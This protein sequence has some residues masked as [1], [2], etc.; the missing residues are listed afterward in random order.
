MEVSGNQKTIGKTIVFVDILCYKHKYIEDLKHPQNA[1]YCFMLLFL[2]FD[3]YHWLLLPSDRKA[4]AKILWNLKSMTKD[5]GSVFSY[6][7]KV[8]CKKKFVK[9][10]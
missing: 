9:L 10:N 5:K 7:V 4:C 2:F 1:E 3:L 6:L 8:L